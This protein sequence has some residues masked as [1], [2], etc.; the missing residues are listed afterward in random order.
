MLIFHRAG[1]HPV[2]ISVLLV[3]LGVYPIVGVG[4]GVYQET[5]TSTAWY[6]QQLFG[7]GSPITSLSRTFCDN[8]N[9]RKFVLWKICSKGEGRVEQINK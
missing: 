8:S 7:G 4:V 3:Y 2:C 9:K 6:N 1:S 5:S